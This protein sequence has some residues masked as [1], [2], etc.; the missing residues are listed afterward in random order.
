MPATTLQ[1]GPIQGQGIYNCSNARHSQPMI[2]VSCR[3]TSSCAYTDT[4]LKQHSTPPAAFLKSSNC[5]SQSIALES[6]SS[7]TFKS[8]LPIQLKQLVE[9]SKGGV[10]TSEGGVAT[11]EGD[12]ET[13]E[14]SVETSVT[15]ALRK[16]II[17]AIRDTDQ[18]S[19]VESAFSPTQAKI[20]FDD[21]GDPIGIPDLQ[22]QLINRK[23]HAF[24]LW[25]ME[26]EAAYE[27]LRHFAAECS[28]IMA[29]TLFDVTEV[30]KHVAPADG[31]AVEQELNEGE[32]Y[33]YIDWIEHGDNMDAN[34]GGIKSF[35]HTNSSPTVT[36]AAL[37]CAKDIPA[38]VRADSRQGGCGDGTGPNRG[39]ITPHDWVFPPCLLD[40]DECE[41]SLMDSAVEI[42]F[43]RYSKWHQKLLTKRTSES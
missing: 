24:P 13:S 30:D 5:P 4:I 28:S 14:G 17:A 10:E 1:H 27:K 20:V 23:K 25:V 19:N 18:G 38:H 29:C 32:I 15:D 42:G 9:T 2:P 22:V 41:A 6:G 37:R 12:V 11:S 16:R 43:T 36:V 8:K 7:R 39:R 21:S 34:A 3:G 31:W 40:W 35:S 26:T 33:N